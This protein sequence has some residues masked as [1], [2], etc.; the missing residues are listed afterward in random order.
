MDDVKS[1]KRLHLNR[2]LSL[3]ETVV[4]VA[5]FTIVML[6]VL[7]SI[8][9]FYRLNGYT[10][11]QTEQVNHARQGTE[12][13]VR[14]L[15]EMTY[16]DNGAFPLV[17]MSS[18]RVGFY[19]DIDRD[20]SVEYV[21]YRLTSSTTLQKRIFNATGTPPSYSTT[22]PDTTFTLSQFV[23]NQIQNTPMFVYYDSNGLPATA[24]TTVADIRYVKL[25][26]IVNIDPIKDPGEYALRSSAT[27]RNL[28]R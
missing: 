9:S 5:L 13:L 21:E 22:T 4:V 14:D 17:V 28:K 7:D 26:I 11:A 25:N 12:Q 3:L 20:N 8:A 15:R 16:A 23:Q 27:L 24:T 6:A 19:S 10:I 1:K 2:G 18:Y